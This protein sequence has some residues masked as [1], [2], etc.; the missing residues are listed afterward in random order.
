[1]TRMAARGPMLWLA[2]LV[3]TVSACAP[4]VAPGGDA[5]GAAAPAERNGRTL[6][7]PE[8]A[9]LP[10]HVWDAPGNAGPEAVVLGV[11]GFND[12]GM[13][14]DL[15]GQWFAAQDITLYAYDQRGFG[16]APNRGVWP[17]VR[18]LARD[19]GR[20]VR[21]AKARHP[22][23]PVYVLGVSMGGGVT[24]AAADMGVLPEVAGVV[25]AA[26][27]VWA[28]ETMPF[29]QRWALWLG[30]H[31]MPWLTLSGA[32]LERTPTDNTVAL[33]TLAMDPKVIG[34]TRVDAIHGLVNL[35]DAAIAGADALPA[36]ALVLY[37]ANDEI[38]PPEPTER[39]WQRLDGRSGVTRAFYREGY[40]MLLRDTQAYTV[41][42]DIRHWMADPDGGLPSKAD[43]R[44]L[45]RLTEMTAGDS[46]S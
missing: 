28:R 31:T 33:R 27:A 46:G 22:E 38:V 29:Y 6:V 1:M 3:L 20:A 14:F 8:G 26:P 39:F 12:Y 23:T 17:G 37:G 16:G 34:E 19:L 18:V 44:A 30:A 45:E 2:A 32:G 36:P 35:M 25:L 15:P 42:R 40:H 21:W 10:L 24:L 43:A 4:R 7:M 13:G 11:H 5:A 41:W 9:H